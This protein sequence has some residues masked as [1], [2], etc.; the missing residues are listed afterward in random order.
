MPVH[1]LGIRSVWINRL[2]EQ[3]EPV[4]TRELTDLRALADVLD[5]LVPYRERLLAY[6]EVHARSRRARST[7]QPER[8][9]RTGLRLSLR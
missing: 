7:F 9:H 1:E 5:E 2:G 3:A 8:L 6:H 4:A